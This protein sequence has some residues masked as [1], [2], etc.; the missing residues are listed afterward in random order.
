[1][2]PHLSFP[3]SLP[4]QMG[5][6]DGVSYQQT[7]HMQEYKY[8]EHI[9]KLEEKWARMKDE[10]EKTPKGTISLVVINSRLRQAE[11]PP[12][13]PRPRQEDNEIRRRCQGM[14]LIFSNPHPCR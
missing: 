3:G 12:A 13:A 7:M 6:V 10:L 4:V 8:N 5:A 11:E 2:D 1:M 9:K 14:T